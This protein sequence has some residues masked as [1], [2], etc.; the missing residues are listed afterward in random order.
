MCSENALRRVVG[1][2]VYPTFPRPADRIHR[3]FRFFRI[4]ILVYCMPSRQKVCVFIRFFPRIKFYCFRKKLYHHS[5]SDIKCIRTVF[6][7][8]IFLTAAKQ[9]LCIPFLHKIDIPFFLWNVQNLPCARR[10]RQAVQLHQQSFR[11]A[12]IIGNIPQALPL[13]YLIKFPCNLFQHT[14]IIYRAAAHYA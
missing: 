3:G 12:E 9:R 1:V 6:H 13:F 10:F 8:K 14:L 11:Y 7:A 2:K 4:I 5:H